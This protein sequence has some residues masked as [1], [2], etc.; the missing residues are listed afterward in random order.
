MNTLLTEEP[1]RETLLILMMWSGQSMV[2]ASQELDV[3]RYASQIAP[4]EYSLPPIKIPFEF[5][6]RSET[7][8]SRT[9]SV[10][11]LLMI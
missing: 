11:V 2:S 10:M 1:S 4:I 6:N 5:T 3:Q 7:S 9:I 8:C